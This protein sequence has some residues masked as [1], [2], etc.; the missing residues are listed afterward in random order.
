MKNKAK[1]A[2]VLGGGGALGF[3]HIGVIDILQQYGVP[4]D[5]VIGTSMGAV[6]GA[7]YC[8]GKSVEELTNLSC[9]ITMSKIFDLNLNFKGLMSGRKIVK[10]LKENYGHTNI[11]DL[12]TKFMCNAVDLVTCKEYIFEHG[13]LLTAVRSS[14]SV[15]AIFSPVKHNGMVL[16]DGGL[17]N[18]LCDDLAKEKGYDI[19]IG[20]DVVSKTILNEN[21]RSLVGSIVQSCLIMQKELQHL[22]NDNCDVLIQPE[23]DTHKQYVFDSESTEQ[24]IELGRL[25][26]L[27][28]MPKIKKVLAKHG[29]KIKDIKK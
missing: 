23:L 8:A 18:N 1:I 7:G 24:M 28:V 14:M 11:D 13:D 5:V 3:S 26:T 22:K 16:V 15:P 19:V 20:V 25:A 21:V 6:I 2:L 29:I 17:I 4:I 12:P 9:E 10:F 27:A